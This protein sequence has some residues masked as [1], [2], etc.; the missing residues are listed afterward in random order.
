MLLNLIKVK[1]MLKSFHMFSESFLKLVF[2]RRLILISADFVNLYISLLITFWFIP[3]EQVLYNV[4]IFTLPF[5]FILFIFTGQ[6]KALSRFVVSKDLYKITSRNLSILIY[7]LII[8]RNLNIFKFFILNFLIFTIL[9]GFMRF[10]FRDLIKIFYKSKTIN[11]SKFLKRALIYGAG[12]AG[13]QLVSSL[14][15]ES[16]YRVCGFIDDDYS[17]HGRELSGHRIYSPNDV[18]RLVEK[19]KINEILIAM[20]SVSKVRRSKIIKKFSCFGIK[21]LQIPTLEEIEKGT[22]DIA[23]LKEIEIEDI[24]QRESVPPNKKLIEKVI[25]NKNIFVTG[26]GGSIGTVLC[27]QILKYNPKNII[28]LERSEFNLYQIEMKLNNKFS[29]Y[30]N[31]IFSYLGSA[32]NK[33]LLEKIFSKHSIEIIFHAAAFKHVPLLEENPLAAIKNNIFTTKL[34][35]HLSEKY[36]IKNMVMISTDKAVRPTNIMGASKRVAE[37]IVQGYAKKSNSNFNSKDSEIHNTTFSIVRFGN[38]L[39][40]SGS[41]VPQFQ[42]QIKRGGP[43]TLTH[44][45]VIRYFMSINEAVELVLQASA[46][47]K[48]GNVLL[49]D[50]GKPVKIYD[51]AIQMIALNGL[52][53][54][55]K[56][57]PSGDIEIITIGLRS[58]E[59]LYE[60]LL[61]DKNSQSTSHP[62]I[63]KGIESSP[64]LDEVLSKLSLLDQELKKYNE[65]KCIEILKCLVP[66]WKN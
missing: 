63:F 61:I 41:V 10:S 48:K 33:T 56:N 66:E 15:L 8:F 37:M 20:P 42:E 52:T 5:S 39:G 36:K 35:C 47:E 21:I 24:L 34:L 32:S 30:K 26:A 22:K 51:L 45:K 38:V 31:N 14:S 19:N 28:L 59:K 17:L 53:V 55:D 6:Y 49:L 40:S 7:Q 29:D 3:I 25:K 18:E 54:K 64:D 4:Y 27:E 23:N 65:K 43:I 9:S 62:L 44:K 11:K 46:L 57:N 58:G 13:S 16:N 12:S 1:K 60:E 50:M 2:L